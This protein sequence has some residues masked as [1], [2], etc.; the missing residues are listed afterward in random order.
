VTGG[1]QQA[2]TGIQRQSAGQQQADGHRSE[3]TQGQ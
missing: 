2:E 1:Q 3:Q